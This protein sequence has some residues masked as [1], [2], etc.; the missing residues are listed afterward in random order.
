MSDMVQDEV[1]NKEKSAMVKVKAVIASVFKI[2]EDEIRMDMT[3]G[4]IRAWDSLGQLLLINS[5]E[6]EFNAV[7][8]IE[9]MFEITSVQDI[10]NIL[11]RK[12]VLS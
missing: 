4:D 9:E 1:S 10:Y 8:E 7:F 12:N 11:Q 3:P 2:Q 6:K 5:L